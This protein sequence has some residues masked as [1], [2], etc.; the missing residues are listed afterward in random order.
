MV[1]VPLTAEELERGKRLGELL[2]GARGEASMVEVAL[3]AGISVE[4]LRKIETGR[5]AT[6]AFFTVAAL[7]QVLGL[8]LD[9]VAEALADPPSRREAAS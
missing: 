7:A 9:L 1:R 5:I 4:T 8:S 6:P 2:R 3:D